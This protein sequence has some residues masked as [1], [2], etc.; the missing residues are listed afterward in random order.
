MSF[1]KEKSAYAK[2]QEITTYATVRLPSGAK[3]LIDV[4]A[5][6]TL[7]AVAPSP[8]FNIDYKKAGRTR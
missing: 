4:K 5:Q 2:T 1:D 8:T 3:R 6:A 7:G